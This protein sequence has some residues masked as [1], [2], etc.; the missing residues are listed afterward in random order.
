MKKILLA[1]VVA[2]TSTTA[3]A[4]D[5]ID[6]GNILVNLSETCP[7]NTRY[8]KREEFLKFKEK[9]DILEWGIYRID[10]TLAAMGSGYGYQIKSYNTNYPPGHSLCV[11]KTGSIFKQDLGSKNKLKQK[12]YNTSFMENVEFDGIQ[13]SL[14]TSRGQYDTFGESYIKKLLILVKK[15]S[16]NLFNITLRPASYGENDDSIS[17]SKI[18]RRYSYAGLSA[19]VS[20]H[21]LKLQYIGTANDVWHPTSHSGSI[22]YDESF[23]PYRRVI[24]WPFDI[25]LSKSV[26]SDYIQ[27]SIYLLTE[28]AKS[29]LNA[30]SNIAISISEA[31]YDPSTG[32]IQT[33]DKVLNDAIYLNADSYTLNQWLN[34]NILVNSNRNSTS[35]PFFSTTHYLNALKPY[36]QAYNNIGNIIY[37]S[38]TVVPL[39]ENRPRNKRCI[40]DIIYGISSFGIYV[41]ERIFGAPSLCGISQ[42]NNQ[43]DGIQRNN[44]AIP[45]NVDLESYEAIE[46]SI[47]NDDDGFNVAMTNL[48]CGDNPHSDVNESNCTDSQNRAIN[49]IG[50]LTREEV[51]QVLHILQEYNNDVATAGATPLPDINIDDSWLR[52]YILENPIEAE[53]L[54]THA[55]VLMSSSRA[56]ASGGPE[57]ISFRNRKGEKRNIAP[58]LGSCA[59]RSIT[60]DGSNN[61]KCIKKVKKKLGK[62]EHDKI[63]TP[64]ANT[65]IGGRFYQRHSQPFHGLATQLVNS[66]VPLPPRYT[67]NDIFNYVWGIAEDGMRSGN[68]LGIVYLPDP[69]FL[70]DRDRLNKRFS[71][72]LYHIWSTIEGGH[73]RDWEALGITNRDMLATMLMAALSNTTSDVEN[74]ASPRNGSSVRTYGNIQ[75]TY[76]NQQYTVTNLR[77]VIGSNGMVITSYP[78]RNTKLNKDS[79]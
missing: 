58:I 59:E 72:G 27:F 48:A 20:E 1:S 55:S 16:A 39:N 51:I 45:S 75:F 23:I 74:R 11:N 38:D 34:Y 49:L 65:Q 77:I 32:V 52:N 19:N 18:N 36:S 2:L 13:S 26:E 28:Q 29:N 43:I 15:D 8:L 21:R 35:S 71:Y 69:Q 53:G 79:N 10:N 44:N 12:F 54:L 6:N 47:N 60:L 50:D 63:I 9:L 7:P 57:L 42:D 22:T 5:E 14:V 78:I 30:P 31:N 41:L 40:E 56:S 62:N 66:Y 76:N 4:I 17:Y 25:A 68:N 37:T 73:R 70:S 64:P 67:I 24:S 3:L 33:G 61:L 46:Q